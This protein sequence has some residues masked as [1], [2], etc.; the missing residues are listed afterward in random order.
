M[1]SENRAELLN[2]SPPQARER[3]RLFMEFADRTDIADVPDP[4]YGGPGG[5][6]LVLDLVE[7]ASV[8]LLAHLLERRSKLGS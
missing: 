2:R 6:E 5:F 4:Y 8:G 7:E 1:D 3:V